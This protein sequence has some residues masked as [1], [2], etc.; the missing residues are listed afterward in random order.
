MGSKLGQKNIRLYIVERY[1]NEEIKYAGD[2]KSNKIY[3]KDL[4][5]KE[6]NSKELHKRLGERTIKERKNRDG[7]SRGELLER[8]GI[9]KEQAQE[10]GRCL[11]TFWRD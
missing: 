9:R 4:Q 11:R 1:E 10:M 3:R 8:I 5:N 6:R 7:K 2:Q